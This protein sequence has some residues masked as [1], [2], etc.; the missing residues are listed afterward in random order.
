MLTSKPRLGVTL[1]NAYLLLFDFIRRRSEVK[2]T[3]QVVSSVGA[4]LQFNP[5]RAQ[6]VFFLVVHR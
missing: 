6:Q 1:C 4:R 3:C 2:L 5:V